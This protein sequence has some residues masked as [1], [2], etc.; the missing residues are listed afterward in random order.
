MFRSLFKGLFKGGFL[1]FLLFFLR[2]FLS[3]CYKACQRIPILFAKRLFQWVPIL[4][5][6]GFLKEGPCPFC[7]K[8]FSRGVL[9]FLNAF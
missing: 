1:S 4:L 7:Q 3:F 5:L 9:S 2:E 8:A 6:K